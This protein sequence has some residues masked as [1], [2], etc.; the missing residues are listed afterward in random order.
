MDRSP[1]IPES[2]WLWAWRR[3]AAWSR[4]DLDPHALSAR[5]RWSVAIVVVSAV[6]RSRYLRPLGLRFLALMPAWMVAMRLNRQVH[7]WY[8]I[9]SRTA[10]VHVQLRFH[11][12]PLDAGDH[13][14]IQNGRL[15]AV[16]YNGKE[17]SEIVFVMT[18]GQIEPDPKSPWM[19]KAWAAYRF[20]Q[21]K[22]RPGHRE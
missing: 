20:D 10:A 1:L 21:M 11:M 5:E 12:W 22:R 16:A 14:R 7:G 4:L 6:A 15:T 8:R 3:I 9:P 19:T 13:V 2:T 17:W 18:D